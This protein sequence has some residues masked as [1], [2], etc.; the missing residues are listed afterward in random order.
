MFTPAAAL[1]LSE[2]QKLAIESLV[3][4]GSTP[5]RVALRGRIILLHNKACPTMPLLSS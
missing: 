4:D 3:R 1:S 5:Q 2:S